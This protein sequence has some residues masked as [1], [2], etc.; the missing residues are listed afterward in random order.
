MDRQCQSVLILLMASICALLLGMH[1]ER[2]YASAWATSPRLI[3]LIAPR[4]DSVRQ[5]NS[6]RDSGTAGGGLRQ[7][8]RA[9]NTSATNSTAAGGAEGSKQ[10]SGR[11]STQ[12]ATGLR[13]QHVVCN[14]FPLPKK[15]EWVR[16]YNPA[17]EQ[18]SSDS[19]L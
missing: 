6:T 1:L 17:G 5:Q 10:R 19:S 4:D 3:S 2:E 16:V 13:S 12:H 15:W 9:G 8:G 7:G 14:G 11:G 18:L